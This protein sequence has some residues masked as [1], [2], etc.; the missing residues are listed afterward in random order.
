M[1]RPVLRAPR[2]YL[3]MVGLPGRGPYS[4]CV[5]GW[6]HC[7]RRVKMRGGAAKRVK[8]FATL[9]RCR[10]SRSTYCHLPGVFRQHVLEMLSQNRVLSNA[11]VIGPN[12]PRPCDSQNI[13][14]A[15]CC[16]LVC[17][18]ARIDFL[19]H[20]KALGPH[21]WRQ[22]NHYLFESFRREF[23]IHLVC[24]SRR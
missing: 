10:H 12:S 19:I 2:I 24:S 23:K 1:D 5:L 4:T 22:L 3:Y 6:T 18:R 20:G 21:F 17:Y 9:L 15:F 11:D 7:A 8:L 14:I 16:Q 13:A